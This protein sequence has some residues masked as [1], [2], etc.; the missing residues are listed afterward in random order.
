VTTL[1]T[2]RRDTTEIRQQ[3]RSTGAV[4]R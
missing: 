4:H 3:R 1:P 2:P